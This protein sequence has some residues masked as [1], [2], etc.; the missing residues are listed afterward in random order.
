MDPSPFPPP[1]QRPLDES[2]CKRGCEPCIFDYYE[3]ALA[4]WE[5]KVRAAG[6][7][8]T[9]ELARAAA[10]AGSSGGG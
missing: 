3:R 6:G 1:P 9:V 7:D 10:K 8:P 2:C 4:R 5:E